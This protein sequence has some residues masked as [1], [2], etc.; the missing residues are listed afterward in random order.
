DYAKH[1]EDISNS[2]PPGGQGLDRNNPRVQVLL[3]QQEQMTE[4]MGQML[5]EEILHVMR[6]SLEKSPPDLTL[7]GA[8]A[9]LT[10]PAR[11]RT[12]TGRAGYPGSYVDAGEASMRLGALRIGDIYIGNI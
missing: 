9:V 7:R 8:H 3:K 4:T 10:C 6:D 1:G 2:M 11:R 12:D 5:G